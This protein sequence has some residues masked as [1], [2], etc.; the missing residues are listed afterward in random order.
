MSDQQWGQDP[1]A[2]QPS[3]WGQAPPPP[4]WGQPPLPRPPHKRWS[5]AK[6]VTVV[7]AG[8]VGLILLTVGVTVLATRQLATSSDTDT[9]AAATTT[10]PAAAAEPATTEP[11]IS[12][13]EPKLSDFDLEVKE[14]KR[15]KF[16]SAGANVTYRIEAGWGPTYHPDKTYELVYEVRGGEDGPVRNY[17]EITGDKYRSE[18]EEYISTADVD[19]RLTVKAVS[20]EEK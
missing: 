18:Q 17:M 16:G 3:Q 12:Y 5:T 15:E 1:T 19:Q 7:L 13:P 8:A 2:P 20:V 9:Q 6:I 4:Q 14:L 10:Q 11:A